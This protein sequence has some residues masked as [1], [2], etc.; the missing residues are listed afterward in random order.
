M[1]KH[2]ADEFPRTYVPLSFRSNFGMEN[3][4]ALNAGHGSCIR[5]RQRRVLQSGNSLPKRFG[6]RQTESRAVEEDFQFRI[7]LELISK[8]VITTER[9][10]IAYAQRADL[11]SAEK[12]RI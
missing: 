9:R 7:N 8:S 4:P 1:K 10:T 5:K 3:L 12:K 6:N 11:L 2:A